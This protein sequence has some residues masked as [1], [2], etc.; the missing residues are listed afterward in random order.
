[1]RY[2]GIRIIEYSIRE[3]FP[4]DIVFEEKLQNIG[5]SGIEDLLV[6]GYSTLLRELNFLPSPNKKKN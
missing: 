4:F 1:M 5:E 6:E 3:S 2:R